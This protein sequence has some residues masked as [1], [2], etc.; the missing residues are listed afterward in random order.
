[1]TRASGETPPV[2]ANFHPRQT[3]EDKAKEVSLEAF[4]APERIKPIDSGE[5]FRP[6]PRTREYVKEVMHL[7]EQTL[8]AVS[9]PS[10]W[11]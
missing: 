6:L 10:A 3:F 7:R 9:G 11:S 2:L 8:E 5:R 1:V 4:L